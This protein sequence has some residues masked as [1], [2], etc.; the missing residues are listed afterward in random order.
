M[1]ALCSPA[2]LPISVPASLPAS[3]Q[4]AR[5]AFKD[6]LHDARCPQQAAE[7][8]GNSLTTYSASGLRIATLIHTRVY[9]SASHN[10]VSRPSCVHV[11]GVRHATYTDD[12]NAKDIRLVI[13]NVASSCQRWMYWTPPAWY[14]PRHA[15][16]SNK[17]KRAAHEAVNTCTRNHQQNIS[18]ASLDRLE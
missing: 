5:R 8:R 4:H 2:C 15:R 13:R 6:T 16:T 1:R 7:R 11:Y 12:T 3:H 17:K 14:G 18:L 10:H 9:H